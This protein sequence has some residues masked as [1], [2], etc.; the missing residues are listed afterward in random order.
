MTVIVRAVRRHPRWTVL[1]VVLAVLVAAGVVWAVSAA[2]AATQPELASAR[3]GTLSR[4]VTVTGTIDPSQRADLDFLAG[5]QVVSVNVSVGQQVAQGQRLASVDAASLPGQTAQAKASL[6]SANA[7]LS[8]DRSA[9]A[10][11]AQIDADEAAVTAAQAQLDVA[12][13]NEAQ[14]TLTA[15]FAGTVAAVNIKVGD[16]LSAGG[17]SGASGGAAS[18]GAGSNRASGG[19]G[20]AG[21][22]GAGSGAAAGAGTSGSGT[23]TGAGSSA[24]ASDIVL[25][26]SGSYVLDA[27]VDDTQVG[28]IKAGQQATITPPGGGAAPLPGTVTSVG[29]VATTTSGVASYPVTIALSGSPTGL[30]LG[31]TAQSDI[32]LE[33]ITDA[34]LVPAVAVRGSGAGAQVTVWADG[35]ATERAVT[36]GATSGGRTQ[37][38]QGLHAGEQVVLPAAVASTTPTA[39]FGG[40][41]GWFGP[42]GG[43]GRGGGAGGPATGGSGR[44]GSAGGGAGAPPAAPGG[45]P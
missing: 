7:R 11:S 13:Q 26:S 10:P 44:V 8:A 23:A 27:T 40:G 34:V 15:P 24:T 3:T 25:V 22:A 19:T 18:S 21:G 9:G 31:S 14:A 39:G 36:V 29:L 5:G 17:S 35:R 42:G 38:V 2:G 37:I 6:A 43:A 45:G 41:N 4:T 28:Q 1:G 32:V 12:E 30:H 20:S 33:Q 16:R